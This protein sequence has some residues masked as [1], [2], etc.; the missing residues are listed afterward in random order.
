MILP[1][2]G[3]LSLAGRDGHGPKPATVL[4][5]THFLFLFFFFIVWI[6]LEYG[7]PRFKDIVLE[8]TPRFKDNKNTRSMVPRTCEKL[9]KSRA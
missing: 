7:R 4:F 8:S 1:A 6:Y 3:R 5:T 9:G 2:M